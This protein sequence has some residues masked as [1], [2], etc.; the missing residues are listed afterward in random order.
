MLI[1]L[2]LP[3]FLAMKFTFVFLNLAQIH[4]FIPI[5]EGGVPGL[6]IIPKKKQ[7]FQYFP[8]NH[9][10]NVVQVNYSRTCIVLE[11]LWIER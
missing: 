6:G 11:P 1:S 9:V 8:Y 5:C 3:L 4:I 7:F 2:G 10:Q